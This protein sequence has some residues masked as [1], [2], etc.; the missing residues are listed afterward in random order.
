MAEKMQEGKTVKVPAEKNTSWLPSVFQA[1]RKAVSGRQKTL[2][3]AE[4][5]AGSYA[6][7]GLVTSQKA[8]PYKCGG[9]V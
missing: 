8:T 7:G 5:K 4:E 1:G 3:E 6:K 2:N 9:K